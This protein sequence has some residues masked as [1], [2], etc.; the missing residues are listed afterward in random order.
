MC[1]MAAVVQ[2]AA[3][4]RTLSYEYEFEWARV[5]SGYTSAR[6]MSRPRTGS[7]S[8]ELALR[9]AVLLTWY[10]YRMA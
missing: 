8:S 5:D 4:T 6:R 1:T 7:S 9:S 2:S 3:R 10:V